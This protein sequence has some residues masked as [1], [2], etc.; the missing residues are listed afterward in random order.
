MVDDL[1]GE[2]PIHSMHP[3]IPPYITLE[4]VSVLQW[5]EKSGHTFFGSESRV[6]VRKEI[7][8]GG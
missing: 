2:T 5:V 1:S 3:H 7:C 8:M 6:K 4:L